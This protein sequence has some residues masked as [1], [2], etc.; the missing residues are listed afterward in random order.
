MPY[1]ECEIR[2]GLRESEVGVTV[3]DVDGRPQRLRVERDFLRQ[4][5][6]TH[7]LP[8]GI[9]ARHPTEDRILIELPLEADSGANRLW[10][11]PDQLLQEVAS[12]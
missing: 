10:V 8:V 3:R 7:Y 11:S 5:A 6:Q 2:P 12:R 9:V 1:V 4:E